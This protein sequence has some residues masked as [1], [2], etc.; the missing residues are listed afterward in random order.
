MQQYTTNLTDKLWQVIEKFINLQGR[1][2]KHF[3][4]NIIVAD[5][6]I[7]EYFCGVEQ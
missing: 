2:R 6:G 5:Y 4:R 3:L 1:K 7:V